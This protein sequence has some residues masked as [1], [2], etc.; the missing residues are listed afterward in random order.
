MNLLR[1]RSE[2]GRCVLQQFLQSESASG[3][4]G[5]VLGSLA[6]V[7]ENVKAG[8]WKDT[9]DDSVL[10]TLRSRLRRRSTRGR[11]ALVYT[12]FWP[13]VCDKRRQNPPI[14]SFI[15]GMISLRN[16]LCCQRRFFASLFIHMPHI[17]Y[18]IFYYYVF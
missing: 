1:S 7:K 16:L 15:L 10:P 17:G 8:T 9:L 2:R 3:L 4:V 6:P 18:F 14:L 12:H 5:S 11:D 13:R